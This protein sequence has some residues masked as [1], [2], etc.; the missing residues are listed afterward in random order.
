MTPEAHKYAAVA[1]SFCFVTTENGE[2]HDIYNLTFIPRVQR[3][4]CLEEVT[5]DSGST[6][7]ELPNGVDNQTRNMLER[8]METCGKVAGARAKRKSRARKGASA[9]EVRRYYKQFVEAKHL[10]WKSWI[11]KMRFLTSLI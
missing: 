3:P 10:G 4:L 11:D 9:Q 1:G 2:Q 6:R 5:D 8:C 7:D